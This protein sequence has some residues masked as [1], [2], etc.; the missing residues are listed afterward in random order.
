MDYR[1]FVGID[2]SKL[3]F[4]AA[5]IHS[6]NYGQVEHRQFENDGNGF[7]QFFSWV[8]AMDKDLDVSQMLFCT[9][10][11]GWYGY[12]LNLFLLESNAAVWVENALQIKLSTGVKRGKSDKSDAQKIAQYCY[13]HRQQAKLYVM[14]DEK[15]IALKQLL[16]FREQLVRQQT[17]LKN[18]EKQTSIVKGKASE[19]IKKV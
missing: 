4:D 7:K 5:V 12:R 6:N 10:N 3:T 2:Q 17:G 13:L 1:L 19:Q 15:L 14:P 16:S 9:E 18:S 8:K 11:T